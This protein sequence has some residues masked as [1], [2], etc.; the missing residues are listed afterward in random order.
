M[1][2]KK[3]YVFRIDNENKTN[4]YQFAKC[5]HELRQ[6]WGELLRENPAFNLNVE[7]GKKEFCISWEKIWGKNDANYKYMERKYNKSLQ[8]ERVSGGRYSYSTKGS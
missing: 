7:Q 3:Y 5:N 2:E 4:I 6:G 8:N 1:M